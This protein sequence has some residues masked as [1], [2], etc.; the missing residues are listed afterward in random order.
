MNRASERGDVIVCSSDHE[1][2]STSQDEGYSFVLNISG[3][4]GGGGGG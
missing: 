3:E 2:V 4:T 1:D